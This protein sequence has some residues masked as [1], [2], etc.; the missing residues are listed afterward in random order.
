MSDIAQACV[1]WVPRPGKGVEGTR[2]L[3][4]DQTSRY[5]FE[6]VSVAVAL[7]WGKGVLPID[8]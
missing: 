3:T 2:I 1:D 5:L 6:Y 7:T 4:I 8:S